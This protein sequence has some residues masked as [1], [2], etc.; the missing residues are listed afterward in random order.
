MSLMNRWKNFHPTPA[1]REQ[2][3]RARALRSVRAHERAAVL[4]E[5]LGPH[6]NISPWHKQYTALGKTLRRFQWELAQ[7]RSMTRNMAADFGVRQHCL[8]GTYVPA[9]NVL[10]LSC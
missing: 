5:E 7:A 10:R 9:I 3:S 2:L 1:Q 6:E 8:R 4:L